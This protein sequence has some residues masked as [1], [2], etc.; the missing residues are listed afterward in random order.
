MTDPL[1]PLLGLPG[2]ADA[3]QAA[4]EAV[5]AVHRHPTNRRGWPATAAEA[6]VRA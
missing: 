2:V 6:S 4:R 3:V 1:V 5:D